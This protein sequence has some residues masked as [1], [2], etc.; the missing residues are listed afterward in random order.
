MRTTSLGFGRLSRTTRQDFNRVII[1][2]DATQAA[3]IQF[4]ALADYVSMVALAQ[5]D[6]DA[7]PTG[8]D[9]ILN[10][11]NDQAA[12]RPTTITEWDLAYLRGLYEAP[13][14]ARNS[15]AQEG[16]IA[17]SMADEVS[18]PPPPQE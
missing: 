12:L 16:A 9:S 2:V 10:L 14:N 18:A 11:F 13:R 8:V 5:I 7:R 6:P 17:R 4:E 3:G 1:I 15:N